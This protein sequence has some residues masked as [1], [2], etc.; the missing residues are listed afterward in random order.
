MDGGIRYSELVFTLGIHMFLLF[1][2]VRQ[3]GGQVDLHNFRLEIF[4][5]SRRRAIFAGDRVQNEQN[6]NSGQFSQHS[7]HWLFFPG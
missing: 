2:E 5:F 4:V 3:K 1:Q 6:H 7:F